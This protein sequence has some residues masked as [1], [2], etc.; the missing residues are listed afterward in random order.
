MI[1]WKINHICFE[2]YEA[3]RTTQT[4]IQCPSLENRRVRVQN[5]PV[6]LREKPTS[7]FLF[8]IYRESNSNL[9][10]D[11]GGWFPL[12]KFGLFLG[13]D[14]ISAGTVTFQRF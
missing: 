13:E 14:L 12:R 7:E 8:L 10:D 1:L 4:S 6:Q 5:S 2:D 11:G 3:G 9:S